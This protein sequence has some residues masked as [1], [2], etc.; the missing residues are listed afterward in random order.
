MSDQ[1]F[2]YTTLIEGDDLQKKS[3]NLRSEDMIND[4]YPWILKS[5][6]NTINIYSDNE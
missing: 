6:V 1:E 3:L 5:T 4:D 2:T